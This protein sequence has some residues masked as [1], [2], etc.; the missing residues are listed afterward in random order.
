MKNIGQPMLLPLDSTPAPAVFVAALKVL[1]QYGTEMDFRRP[2]AS[3]ADRI[4]A[5]QQQHTNSPPGQIVIRGNDIRDHQELGISK[6]NLEVCNSSRPVA[7]ANA[8]LSLARHGG[9]I[10]WRSLTVHR[11][12]HDPHRENIKPSMD[13][14]EQMRA[15]QRRNYV[16]DNHH[17]TSP[18]QQSF[19]AE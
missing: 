15:C 5:D 19:R 2:N 9:F 18:G 3:P 17:G 11:S 10:W 16:F 14:I 8:S 6:D 12:T 13:E 7:A 1:V 4:I